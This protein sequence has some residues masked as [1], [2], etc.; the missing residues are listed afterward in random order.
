MA[1]EFF[2]AQCKLKI[3]N[4]PGQV[5]SSMGVQP[6]EIFS[7]DGSEPIN[8]SLLLSIGAAVRRAVPE[9]EPPKPMRRSKK[10][11]HNA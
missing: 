10:V 7:L 2:V 1:E 9:S 8:V 5:P 4:G 6:G 3:P 11:V